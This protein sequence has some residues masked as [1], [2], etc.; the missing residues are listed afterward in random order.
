MT[1]TDNKP[2]PIKDAAEAIKG[3]AQALADLTATRMPA[4]SQPSY[5]EVDHPQHYGGED[6]PYE[7]IKIIEHFDLGFN[8][9]NALKY[10]LRA[11][12][13]PGTPYAKD[14]KKALWYLQHE[15]ERAER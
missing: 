8:T 5:E 2:N 9:G 11:G 14:L 7:V 1:T 10:L 15:V 12:R 4:L 13:K 6:S 3:P